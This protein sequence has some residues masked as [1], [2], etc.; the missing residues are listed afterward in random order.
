[1]TGM[2][3]EK[4]ATSRIEE[5]V[6]LPLPVAIRITLRGLKIRLGRSLITMSGVVLGIAFLMSV[7]TGE[8]LRAG[9]AEETQT[10]TEVARLLNLV[11]DEIGTFEG[12]KV[13]VLLSGQM[14]SKHLQRMLAAMAGKMDPGALWIFQ[15]E[16][17]SMV[18][19]TTDVLPGL[20][21]PAFSYTD[22]VDEFFQ[23]AHLV[24]FLDEHLPIFDDVTFKQY[25]GVMR[26]PV[27]LDYFFG[28]YSEEKLGA[29]TAKTVYASL[30]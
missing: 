8:G 11:E 23:D 4:Q 25:L 13:G 24:L 27:V 6:I 10:K 29:L 14:K 20:N 16:P 21:A 30:S 2:S 19:R 17:E 22:D 7:L 28:R 9:L 26:Q 15:T 3:Q 12:R 5:Q 1:M 18:L